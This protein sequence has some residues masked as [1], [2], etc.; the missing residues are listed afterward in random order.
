MA[1]FTGVSPAA[2]RKDILQI[3]NNNA[4]I[5]AT[6]RTCEDGDGKALPFGMSLTEFTFSVSPSAPQ[7]TTT[8]RFGHNATA[9]LLTECSVFGYGAVAASRGSCVFG[10]GAYSVLNDY[11]FNPIIFGGPP[12]I[13]GSEA[14]G[15]GTSIGYQ[16]YTGNRE[17]IAIGP[18]SQAPALATI[19][20]GDGARCLPYAG[21][22]AAGNEIVI[23]DASYTRGNIS[24]FIGGGGGFNHD[25]TIG[26]GCQGS[27][28][29]YAD[30]FSTA[31]HQGF[32]GAFSNDAGAF[33][34][35]IGF[36][37][38]WYFGPIQ[39]AVAHA[40]SM[41]L[42]S[43]SGLNNAGVDWTFNASR[44]T[45]NAT[46]GALV[47]QTSTAGSSSSTLQTLSTKLK[48][49]GIGIGFFNV[50]PVARQV[51]PTGSSTDAVITALQNLGLFSQS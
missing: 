41:N 42:V 31:A 33:N 46:P 24:F 51:V 7:N 9:A 44:G 25:Y 21:E 17:A 45:G 37:N 43:G 1:A 50:N 8:E 13:Y 5:D 29:S 12:V 40:V 11:D 47:F 18:K 38:E 32:L 22:A 36:I 19:A 49:N 14:Y 35:G 48:I 10:Y 39:S 2:S 26:L 27:S 34:G 30:S 16:A 3:P 28:T 20:I 6:L 23:G 4:G 15:K